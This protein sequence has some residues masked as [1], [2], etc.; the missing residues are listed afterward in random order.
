MTKSFKYSQVAVAVLMMVATHAHAQGTITSSQ[1][2]TEDTTITVDGA[3]SGN[4]YAGIVAVTPSQGIPSQIV[5][6]MGG[7]YPNY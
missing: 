5:V 4:N 6:G 2:F 3:Y 7:E 1:E